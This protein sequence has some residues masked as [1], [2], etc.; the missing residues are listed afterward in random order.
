MGDVTV[1]PPTIYYT[2]YGR[3]PSGIHFVKV[4]LGFSDK[5]KEKRQIF[6]NL[7][8]INDLND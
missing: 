1:A 6:A 3:D 5:D 7:R 8:L 2:V 4:L